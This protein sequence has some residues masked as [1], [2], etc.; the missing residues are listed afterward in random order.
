MSATPP[1][2]YEVP[3]SPET[4]DR[5]T[6]RKTRSPYMSPEWIDWFLGQQQR[7][8]DSAQQLGTVSL[9]AQSADIAATPI[10]MPDLATGKYRVSVYVR[11]TR[12]ASTSSAI[13]IVIGW[14]DGAIALT[15]AGTDLTGN[16][17][18][19]FEQRTLVLAVD[20]NAALTYEAIYTSV[21]ATAMTFKLEIVCE[22]LPT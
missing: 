15:S 13:Q 20:A 14:T 22:Q 9:S 10:P 18:S 4:V 11:V 6:G 1:L 16:T 8:E 5:E 19:T 17:T 12:A 21:G 3:V 7:N 2:P